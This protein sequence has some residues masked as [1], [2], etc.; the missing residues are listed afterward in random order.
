MVLFIVATVVFS[1]VVSAFLVSLLVF[2]LTKRFKRTFVALGVTSV[3]SFVVFLVGLF[4]FLGSA[5]SA[6]GLASRSSGMFMI[7]SDTLRD[8]VWSFNAR[9]AN[10]RTTRTPNFTLEHMSAIAVTGQVGSGTAWLEFEQDTT[11]VAVEMA[12][13]VAQTVDLTEFGL[14]PGSVR[15]TLRFMDARDVRLQVDWGN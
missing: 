14:V 13:Q 3:L 11:Q 12:G 6:G 10:G 9:S 5:G 7:S 2:M 8:G 4:G 15:V 1:L